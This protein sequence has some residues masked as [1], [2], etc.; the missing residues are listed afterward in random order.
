MSIEGSAILWKERKRTMDISLEPIVS[1][2][3][4]QPRPVGSPGYYHAREWLPQWMEEVGLVPYRGDAFQLSY[5]APSFSD[6]ANF[7]GMLPGKK[8]REPAILL[9]AHYDTV[10]GCPG[11]D[12]NAAA[13]A[14][15][16]E[17]V[18]RISRMHRT[19]PIIAAFFDAEEPPYFLSESMGS[20]R[21]HED[22]LRHKVDC[23]LILDL[24]GHD[25]PLTGFEDLLFVTGIESHPHLDAMIQNNPGVPGL[26]ILPTQNRYIGDM[27]DHHVFRLAGVPYLFF[28]CGRWNHYHAPSD[29]PQVNYQKMGAIVAYLE[30]LLPGLDRRSLGGVQKPHDT[31]P[32]ELKFFNTILGFALRSY[33]LKRLS[34]RQDIDR[35]VSLFMQ[36]FRL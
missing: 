5:K 3:A 27:S 18:S 1:T 6:F 24:V 26:R 25:V 31:T 15:I 14:V 35:V 7:V 16:F 36:Q 8:A 29:R 2:L 4:R 30:R 11:A 23:A 34:S 33:G 17:V 19:R 22:Q 13:I 28:S 20:K 12:D 10:P 32:T 21:F 9:G